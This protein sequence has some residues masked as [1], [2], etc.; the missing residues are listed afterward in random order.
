MFHDPLGGI[1][2]HTRCGQH[3]GKIGAGLEVG[4]A[5]REK[6]AAGFAQVCHA[7]CGALRTDSTVSMA[8]GEPLGA[9]LQPTFLS[10][11]VGWMMLSFV[12]RRGPGVEASGGVPG[13]SKGR[14]GAD[15]TSK[16]RSPLNRTLSSMSRLWLCGASR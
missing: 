7:R 11:L 14:I 16:S 1:R 12:S 4:K 5:Y 3:K 6:V 13:G 2:L 9:R 10:A 8:L 15:F